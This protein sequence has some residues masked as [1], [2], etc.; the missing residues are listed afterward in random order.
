MAQIIKRG[1]RW[2]ARVRKQGV[3]QSASFV[4]KGEAQAW[5]AQVEADIGAGRLGRAV[6]RSFGEL[7]QRYLDEVVERKDGA[8]WERVRVLRLLGTKDRPADPLVR[9]RLPL[10]GPEHFAAWRDRRLREVSAATVRREWNL[11]SSICSISLKEW[12]WIP[13][14]PMRGVSL[15]PSPPPRTRRVSEEETERLLLACGYQRGEMATTAQARVGAAFLFALETAMRA[16]EICALRWE[17]IGERLAKVR[18]IEKGAR[19][20]KQSREVPLSSAARAVLATLP[21]DADLAFNLASASVDALFR[22]A[23]ARAMIEGLHFHDSRAEALTRLSAKLDVMQLARV[24]GH[25]DL[26][27]LYSVYYRARGEDL[28]GLLD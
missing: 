14:H 9:V 21:R 20:T 4:R 19:K 23:K 25:K 16:G 3:S 18:A 7:L 13:E 27:I 5:A 8:R 28:A 15:P 11:L 12:R 24:S 1:E 6:D 26:R 10:I 22:K 2:Q 17:D